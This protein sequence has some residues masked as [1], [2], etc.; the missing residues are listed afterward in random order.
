VVLVSGDP[1]VV[2]P[3]NAAIAINDNCDLC[4]TLAM[5]YQFV[6]NT[7][8]EPVHFTKEGK[9]RL[10]E[11]KKQFKELQK[12]DL[13]IDQVQAQVAILAQQVNDVVVNEL[14]TG[15]PGQAKTEEPGASAPSTAAGE[16]TTTT[17]APAASTTT[18]PSTAA[19]TTAAPL[20]TTSSTT[21]TSV[22]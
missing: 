6:F 22:P 17:S 3:E 15:P 10:H 2:A 11:F 12:A 1:S 8:D 21:T 19:P 7:G 5:A 9:A 13:P 20:T 14:V 18:P 16:E 4:N